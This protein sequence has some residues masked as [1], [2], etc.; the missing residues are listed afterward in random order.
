[1]KSYQFSEI[2][3]HFY[4]KRE[5]M[6]IQQSMREK[7]LRKVGLCFV[8]VYI[9]KPLKMSVN[10]FFFN[11]FFCSQYFFLFFS[12]AEQFTLLDIRMI[13]EISK[14]EIGNGK[15]LGI[16]NYNIHLENNFKCLVMKA[17]QINFLYWQNVDIYDA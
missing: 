11:R 5:K 8:T 4:K 10:H 12:F 15:L 6:L 2:Y 3:K 13:Q 9:I 14:G 17:T 1:M 7:K 16:A